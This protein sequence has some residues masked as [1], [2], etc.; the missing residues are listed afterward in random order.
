M[1]KSG[2]SGMKQ[3]NGRTERQRDVRLLLETE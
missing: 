2:T 3:M 1:S